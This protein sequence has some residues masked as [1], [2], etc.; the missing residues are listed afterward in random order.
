M[1]SS[2]FRG[3]VLASVAVLAAACGGGGG[4]Q[5]PRTDITGSFTLTAVADGSSFAADDP[6]LTVLGQTIPLNVTSSASDTWTTDSSG[7]NDGFTRSWNKTWSPASA[8]THQHVGFGD[9]APDFLAQF[10]S[11]ALERGRLFYFSQRV[12]QVAEAETDTFSATVVPSDPP[13][14]GTPNLAFVLDCPLDPGSATFDADGNTMPPPR[15]AV[16][17]CA[18]K[19][20]REMPEECVS[21]TATVQFGS[22]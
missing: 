4:S 12:Q 15:D 3:L 9:T 11:P 8:S 14:T 22:P 17:T 20:C 6:V 18:A 16:L 13:P 21:G 2:S 5:I 19:L 1:L 7:A 10:M